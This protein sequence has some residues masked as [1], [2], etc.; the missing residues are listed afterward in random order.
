MINNSNE[1][2][3]MDDANSPDLN[4]KIMG[5][6][7]QDFIRVADQL[8]EASYQIRKR[9]FSE[10]PIFAV[11]NNEVD[12]GVLLIGANELTNRYVYKASYMQEFVDRKLIGE[13]SVLLFTENYKNP[14][15]YCCLFALIGEFSGFVFVP[16][17]ED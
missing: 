6:I 15:E 13:E 2:A 7:S 12:L 3:L 10:H 17:P 16:Y 1:N 11:T 5:F 9:G 4:Q 14:D 8:K